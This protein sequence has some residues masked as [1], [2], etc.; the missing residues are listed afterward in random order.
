MSDKPTIE[1]VVAHY[2]EDLS[3]LK[4]VADSCIVYSKGGD[5]NVP[6]FPH[7]PLENIGREGH[8]YL[9]HLVKR[10]HSLPEVTI[11]LQGRIDDHVSLSIAEIVDKAKGTKPGEVVT[12]PFRELELFDLWDGIPWEKY[13]CWKKWATMDCKSMGKTPGELF[14]GI[15]MSDKVPASVGFQPGAIFAVHRDTIQQHPHRFY[16]RLLRQLF[17]GEMAH[18]NPETGHYLERFWLAMWDPKEYICWD[19]KD[20][21]KEKHNDKGQLAKGHWHRTPRMVDVDEAILPPTTISAS[22]TPPSIS[23]PDTLSSSNALSMASSRTS[24]SLCSSPEPKPED[25]LHQVEKKVVQLKLEK[26]ANEE[27]EQDSEQVDETDQSNS[28]LT[29]I[30]EDDGWAVRAD[31]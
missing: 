24:S 6:E 18:I 1:V 31:L 9:A 15:F 21:A 2:N 20:V 4:E 7:L 19:D 27:F 12:F 8:T 10:Y 22:V 14:K 28:K 5:K 23:S 16:R 30:P 13:P 17:L 3:W 29:T 25:V 11:F 26:D